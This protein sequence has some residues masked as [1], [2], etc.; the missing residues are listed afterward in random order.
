[1]K[2]WILTLMSFF[3]AT[4][5]F[6]KSAKVYTKGT[7]CSFCMK[8]IEKRF[9][10]R[11]EVKSI[12]FSDEF[13]YVVLNF[14]KDQNITDQAIQDEIVKSGYNVKKIERF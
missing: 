12:Q 8:G 6:A 2:I 13:D 5:S 11:K 3:I 7:V 4:V 14:K 10:S 9:K 1:M